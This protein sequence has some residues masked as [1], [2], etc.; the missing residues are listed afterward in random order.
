MKPSDKEVLIVNKIVVMESNPILK[1]LNDLS[2][3]TKK[4]TNG[5]LYQQMNKDAKPVK[6]SLLKDVFTPQTIDTIK[7]QIQPKIKE[8]YKNATLLAYLFPEKTPFSTWR[9]I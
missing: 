6:I 2:E 3:I 8:C 7:G 5:A 1:Y 9:D 4:A